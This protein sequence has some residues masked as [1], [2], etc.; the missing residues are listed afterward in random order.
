M[1]RSKP[2]PWGK[3]VS[4]CSPLNFSSSFGSASLFSH[5]PDR[6]DFSL[7]LPSSAGD[8]AAGQGQ[9]AANQQCAVPE[10]V[11]WHDPRLLEVRGRL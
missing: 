8:R 1:W 2:S 4:S 11:S 9:D 7:S 10:G 5:V 6:A 3:I